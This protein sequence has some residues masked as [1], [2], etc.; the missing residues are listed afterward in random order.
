[1]KDLDIFIGA[2]KDPTPDELAAYLEEKC[3]GDAELRAK[4]EALFAAA[5][6]LDPKFLLGS[7]LG[8]ATTI[9]IER[10]AKPGDIIGD[11]KLVEKIGEGGC[12]LVYVADQ[13][14]PVT[15]RVALKI[16][17]PGMD[18]RE[19]IAR[20]EV[21]RQALALMDH[22]NIAKV[23]DAGATEGG[24]PFFVME[25]VR[26]FPITTFCDDENLD[27]DRRLKLFADVCLAVQHAHQKGVIHRDLKPSN[28]MVAMHD[29][30]P[31]VKVIDFGIAKAT[32]QSLTEKTLFTQFDQFMG[33]PAYMSPEQAKTSG[34][35][36][37]TRSDIYALGVLL[38]ELL[39]GHTPFDHTDLRKAG[40]DEIRR[41]IREDEP[42]RPSTRLST[43]DADELSNLARHRRAE[44]KK[45][46]ALIRGDLDWIVMKALDKD[47]TRR[48]DTA[49][50]FAQDIRHFLSDEPV[51]AA[52]PSV[53]YK[54][55]KFARRHQKTLAVA[56]A[57][58]LT[59]VG[60]TVF[61]TIQAISANTAWKSEAKAFDELKIAGEETSR[62]LVESRQNEGE[63]W[64]A[65]ARLMLE[66][67]RYL[68]VRLM[69]GRAL[70]FEPFDP[71]SQGQAFVRRYQPL[72][73]KGSDEWLEAEQLA[74]G[75]RFD[76]P[77]LW[78]TE[79]HRDL[80]RQVEFSPDGLL[81]ASAGFDG[82]VV[83]WDTT[84]G[85]KF[86][87]LS[88]GALAW[89]VAFSP[90]GS[91]LAT[92][93]ET[94]IKLWDLN[95]P[96]PAREIVSDDNVIALAFSPH[97]DR[98]ASGGS[99]IR[100]WDIATAKEIGSF[101]RAEKVTRDV[102]FSPDGNLIAS[103][104]FDERLLLWDVG[105]GRNLDEPNRPL[106]QVPHPDRLSVQHAVEFHPDG[107]W[108]A[109]AGDGGKLHFFTVPGL[110]RIAESPALHISGV[111]ALSFSSDGDMIA[112]SGKDKSVRV[113][114]VATNQ[115]RATLDGHHDE[116]EGVD[117]GR[118]GA[119]LASCG[120]DQTVRL[121]DV[122]KA[123]APL[124]KLP[125]AAIGSIQLSEAGALLAVSTGMKVALYVATTAERIDEIEF[126]TSVEAFRLSPDGATLA[127]ACADHQIYLW[128]PA[129]SET[130]PHTRRS[131]G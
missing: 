115:V 63:A 19:V 85:E 33:T 17:K 72:L 92:G 114:D 47:R 59:L 90:D 26:G 57:F 82:R 98:L 116:V 101:Q 22:P 46:S 55:K 42:R 112:S 93:G 9:G 7:P 3:A 83:L 12:G 31:V 89:D 52:A 129:S 102:A 56:T 79:A 124:V 36:I 6:S 24:L 54:L 76:Y 21:E 61:S 70:G 109:C 118:D 68:N 97:G 128:A 69:A 73:R 78:A 87:E 100:L 110:K 62:L 48:Y 51:L 71:A 1:M 38:Y 8:L 67:K 121:W 66:Q 103:V 64:L 28:V 105:E 107:S 130:P 50:G 88:H 16:I 37:D 120:L 15:R 11:F 27:T 131:C 44:P 94:L 91:V 99:N 58:A 30:V 13:L 5:Q 49:A 53:V 45:L 95:S 122:G 125:G 81:L 117:F 96:A 40:I 104:G 119:L 25:L 23:F 20:F 106:R 10:G 60:A 39:T 108:L 34:L 80:V 4:V 111:T 65:G 41:V 126:E 123:A 74:I 84:T 86:R 32:Q 35:D 75:E 77:M 2:P 43:L 29:D 18:S 14:R 113:W 127:V